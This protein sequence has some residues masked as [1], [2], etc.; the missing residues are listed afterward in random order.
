MILF[1]A[2]DAVLPLP[3]TI[4]HVPI[5]QYKENLKKIVTHPNITAHNPTIIV[6]T[7]PPLDEIRSRE[8]DT[9]EHGGPQRMHRVSADYSQKAR[10]VA[11]EVPGVILVDLWQ[12]IMDAAAKDTPNFSA[13]AGILGLDTQGA[14]PSYHPDGLHMSGK[15]YR[16]LYNE[17]VPYIKGGWL[18]GPPLF[19]EWRDINPPK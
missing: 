15:A 1:G 13:D 19:P 2:N 6:I 12:A 3:T 18:D 16:V 17:V 10:D 7:P 4:Q 5:D 9:P 11:A 8:L 14:L